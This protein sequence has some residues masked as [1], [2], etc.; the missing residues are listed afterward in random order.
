MCA[1]LSALLIATAA[2]AAGKVSELKDS[3]CSRNFEH[4]SEYEMVKTG[5]KPAYI[6]DYTR[7]VFQFVEGGNWYK[8]EYRITR[9]TSLSFGWEETKDEYFALMVLGVDNIDAQN[10]MAPPRLTVL[11]R[12]ATGQVSFG[13]R[14]TFGGSECEELFHMPAASA[15][16]EWCAGETCSPIGL[17][18]SAG[19]QSFYEEALVQLA[20]RIRH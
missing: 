4:W 6:D 2:H 19:W 1:V 10:L 16:D 7:C 8:F 13:V 14:D 11:D 3:V 17:Q 9:H 18:Y 5:D 12:K 15:L 20:K